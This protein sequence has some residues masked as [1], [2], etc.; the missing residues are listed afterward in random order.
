MKCARANT[1]PSEMR[2]GG[3]E[4]PKGDHCFFKKDFE[5]FLTEFRK[6]EFSND[7]F[8]NFAQPFKLEDFLREFV[9]EK[10]IFTAGQVSK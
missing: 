2:G 8:A 10:S 3:G 9:K 1:L 6:K 4:E 7:I 5:L